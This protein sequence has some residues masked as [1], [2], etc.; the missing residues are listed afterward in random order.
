MTKGQA[1]EKKATTRLF[2]VYLLQSSCVAI[3]M[4]PRHSDPR[5]AASVGF[6]RQEYWDAH[7]MA[8]LP[9]HLQGP[10]QRRSRASL[11][12]VLKIKFRVSWLLTPPFS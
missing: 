2:L 10:P 8:P 11:R 1:E 6:A 9:Q 12:L 3:A 4:V 7:L 5:G